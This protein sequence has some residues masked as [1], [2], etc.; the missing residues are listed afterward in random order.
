M[1]S[2]ITWL[3]ATTV[4]FVVALFEPL[5]TLRQE[6]RIE[7][8]SS[9]QPSVLGASPILCEALSD[10]RRVTEIELVLKVQKFKPYQGLFQ[11]AALNYG[12]RLEI[13]KSGS[14][15]VSFRSEDAPGGYGGV[16][17]IG[18]V[19][20]NEPMKIKVAIRESSRVSI[21]LNDGPDAVFV[22]RI[23][24]E[25][26]DLRVGTGFDSSRDLAGSV[27][28]SLRIGREVRVTYFGLPYAVRQVAQVAFFLSAVG[29][30]AVV[31]FER[32]RRQAH[33]EQL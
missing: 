25:C 19:R 11:T 8:R 28:G 1:R 3:V 33:V 14:L 13:D 26:T 23:T 27:Q 10:S 22:G 30:I 2:P 32:G 6:E 18:L 12:I 9:D 21:S 5:Q 7:L 17:A 4:C 29:L 15:A 31:S 20:R 24:A 16:T